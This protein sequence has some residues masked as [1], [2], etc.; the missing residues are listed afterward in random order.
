MSSSNDVRIV[1]VKIGSRT[2]KELGDIDSL[3]KSI[4]E[5][6]LLHPIVVTP[7]MQLVVGRRRIEAYKRLKRKAIPAIVADNQVDV[8]VRL[9]AE[10]DENT[11]RKDF[12][13][14]ESVAI[15]KHVAKLERP[16]AIKRQ[17]ESTSKAGKASGK[18]RANAR[19]IC[20]S[21]KQD[22]AARTDSVAAK[23][24]GMSRRTYERAKAVCDAADADPQHK[25]L[26]EQMDATGNITGTH[27]KLRRRLE[28]RKDK[29]ERKRCRPKAIG[30][31]TVA[32]KNIRTL[33][34]E[35]K[36][37]VLRPASQVSFL[38]LRKTIEELCAAVAQHLTV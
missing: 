18:A 21:V 32:V 14:S 25:D 37:L 20:P 28:G 10:S 30:L 13:P 16:R 6:G 26:V 4:E 19:D 27:D 23:A 15:G 7:D 33:A 9:L 3:A 22:E 36:R 31:D 38:D 2:R 12:T 11:C 24:G 34:K 29:P 35:A 5:I 17:E 1:D 8:M